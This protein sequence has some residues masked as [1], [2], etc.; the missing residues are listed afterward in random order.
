MSTKREK[1]QATLSEREKKKIDGANEKVKR[2][3]KQQQRRKKKQT[4]EST[5]T[6]NI[7]EFLGASM[8][9]D[10]PNDYELL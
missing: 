2:V 5:K 4:V 3:D 7:D 9:T 10:K 6:T 1:K 8:N